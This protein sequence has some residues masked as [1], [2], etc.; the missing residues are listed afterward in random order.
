MS[1]IMHINIEQA[2]MNP[3]GQFATPQ[4]L[5]ASNALTLGQKLAAL[6]RWEFQVRERLD[7]SN[8]GMPSH[9][10]NPEEISML[11]AIEDARAS[12]SQPREQD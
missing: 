11:E 6:N 1:E 9:G 8:E 4:D 3:A 5:A 2:R 7:A 12:L 10:H